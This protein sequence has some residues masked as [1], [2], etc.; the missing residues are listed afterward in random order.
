MKDYDYGIKVICNI[1]CSMIFI[2]GKYYGLCELLSI[3]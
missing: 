1:Y 3:P 2:L